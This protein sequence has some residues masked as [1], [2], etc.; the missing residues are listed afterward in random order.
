[1]GS[2][3]LSQ[4]VVAV[5]SFAISGIPA[6]VL[7]VY[8]NVSAWAG[9]GDEVV[10]VDNTGYTTPISSNT[11]ETPDPTDILNR[12]VNNWDAS[13]YAAKTVSADQIC[14]RIREAKSGNVS[15]S[16]RDKSGKL[17]SK[18]V[19]L[20][21]ACAA[22]NPGNRQLT[23]YC[24]LRKLESVS[25]ASLY[26]EASAS[27][28]KAN[29]NLQTILI[30]DTA[31][32]GVCWA[33]YFL[34][35]AAAAA[36]GGVGSFML[37]KKPL[38]CAVGAIAAAGGELFLAV[39]LLRDSK[40]FNE[41]FYTENGAV[42]R[43]SDD[44]KKD[45]LNTAKQLAG[46]GV[47]VYALSK[48]LCLSGINML[49]G[50]KL[51]SSASPYWDHDRFNQEQL[52]IELMAASPAD[53]AS[54][55]NAS[56]APLLHAFASVVQLVL[57][58]E[59]RA[60]QITLAYW[61]SQVTSHASNVN[62]KLKVASATAS[63]LA[64]LTRTQANLEGLTWEFNPTPNAALYLSNQLG[65]NKKPYVQ[66]ALYQVIVKQLDVTKSI[67]AKIKVASTGS[68]SGSNPSSPSSSVGNVSQTQKLRSSIQAASS[69]LQKAQ[70]EMNAVGKTFYDYSIYL[71][72]HQKIED[73][74]NILNQLTSD[75]AQY[76]KSYPNDKAGIQS[77]K[78]DLTSAKNTMNV[79]ANNNANRYQEQKVANAQKSATET[80]DTRS[81]SQTPS[82]ISPANR[83]VN[84]GNGLIGTVSSLGVDRVK[85]VVTTAASNTSNSN[86][87]A[88]P[89]AVAGTISSESRSGLMKV[90]SAENAAYHGKSSFE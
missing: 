2:K 80:A 88:D 56:G 72:N 75:V 19:N 65:P 47:G 58:Q 24:T 82:T 11:S 52:A 48:A 89:S 45:L 20:A 39:D 68:S 36:T 7:L 77:L 1:M 42:K 60:A 83:A 33:E 84:S 16:F 43:S 22:P 73:Q 57:I 70:S 12:D 14:N 23:S 49:C 5:L 26:C 44:S 28:K 35:K 50:S 53:A 15:I 9:T 69:A 41:D 10:P 17:A 34:S 76:E 13:G 8:P 59:A 74:Q 64:T 62:S 85:S 4:A 90:E 81:S 32:A 37:G 40:K 30:L 46:L 6:A 51:K 78:Q 18:S 21:E 38:A 55:V 66:Q 27:A 67:L 31:A 25:Q 3:L 87:G 71:S 63:D 29:K 86:L 54:G 79:L 61:Q